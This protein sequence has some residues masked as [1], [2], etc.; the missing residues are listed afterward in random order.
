MLSA[1]RALT[2]FLPLLLLAAP[3]AAAQQPPGTDIYLVDL[4]V[5]RD[6]LQLGTPLNITDREGYDNQPS[7][8]ADGRSVLYTSIR[9]DGQADIYRYD[10]AGRETVRVTRTAESEYSPTHTPDGRGISVVR[11][12]PDSTQRLWRFGH[13]GGEPELLLSEIRPVGYHAWADEETVALFVLGTPATLQLADLRTGLAEVVAKDIGRSLHQ[14]PG[15]GAIS[16]LRRTA[17]GERWIEELDV[18]SRAVRPL[19]RPLEQGEDYAWTPDGKLLMG[20]GA[21]LFVWDPALGGDWREIADLSAAGIGEIT[22]LAVSPQGDRLAL[23]AAR[24]R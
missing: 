19:V 12:E 21:K 16:F 1:S 24:G 23:V 8:T 4:E 13:D 7:F 9:E 18:A 2:L 3:R 15:R 14:I 5:Q 17:E 10:I 6:R 11:V 22:R 20:Q